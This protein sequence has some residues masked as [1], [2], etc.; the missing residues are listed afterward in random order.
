MLGIKQ[1]AQ[2]SA[3]LDAKKANMRLVQKHLADVVGDRSVERVAEAVGLQY[4][5]AQ[6]ACYALALRGVCCVAMF[7][8]VWVVCSSARFD[9]VSTVQAQLRECGALHE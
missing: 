6:E 1:V 4:S 3:E 2:R 9:E 7:N 5:A 8:G